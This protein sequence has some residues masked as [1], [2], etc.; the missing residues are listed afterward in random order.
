MVDAS[1]TMVYTSPDCNLNLNTNLLANGKPDPLHLILS[2]GAGLSAAAQQQ[3]EGTT[4]LP[5]GSSRND[6]A[7]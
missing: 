3:V 2:T 6:K 4:T 7:L 1:T 5:L